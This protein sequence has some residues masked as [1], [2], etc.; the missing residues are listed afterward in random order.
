MEGILLPGFGNVGL[1]RARDVGSDKG[2]APRECSMGTKLLLYPFVGGELAQALGD[3]PAVLD[4]EE[5]QVTVPLTQH[6]VVCL[7]YLF[8]G[9]SEWGE[10]IGKAWS[11]EFPD[12]AM[13]V[14][15]GVV[16]GCHLCRMGVDLGFTRRHVVVGWAGSS[17]LGDRFR[18]SIIV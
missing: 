9:G 5:S 10:G 4:R 12:N 13:E 15:N 17:F 8:W 1:E 16:E 2:V 6:E 18:L 3:L 14:A 7:P 11:S